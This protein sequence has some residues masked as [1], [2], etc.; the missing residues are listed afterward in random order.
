M[1]IGWRQIPEPRDA[2]VPEEV[3]GVLAQAFTS[4]ARVT[5]P[6]SVANPSVTGVWSP[7]GDD[8]SRVL[9]SRSFTERIRESLQGMAPDIM[10]TST[11]RPERVMHLFDDAAYPWW[12]QGQVVLLSGPEAAPPDINREMLLAL[13]RDDWAT[14]AAHLAPAGIKAVFRPGVD[15]D[16]A[17]LFSLSEAFEHALIA[18]LESKTRVAGFD[19][20]LLRETEFAQQQAASAD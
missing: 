6:S 12:L 1:L 7:S 13:Y 19:W 11:R 15:G 17:G 3:A 5:F 10:L 2:G 18:T 14:G 8:L 20:A 4:V 16:V 9:P